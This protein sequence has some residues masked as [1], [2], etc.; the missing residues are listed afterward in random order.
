[1]TTQT[2]TP[3]TVVLTTARGV[4]F[5]L[6]VRKSPGLAL[7]DAHKMITSSVYHGLSSVRLV[8]AYRNPPQHQ[9]IDWPY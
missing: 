2:K 3:H 7:V 8:D 9:S 1:M 4:R 6:N 5:P